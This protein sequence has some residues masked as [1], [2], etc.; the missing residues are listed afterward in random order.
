MFN[1]IEYIIFFYSKYGT[2]P[3]SESISDI[4]KKSMFASIYISNIGIKQYSSLQEK[5]STAKILSVVRAKSIMDIGHTIN[6][7]KGVL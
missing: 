4:N 1:K 3:Q 2:E 5:Y 7:R 6:T